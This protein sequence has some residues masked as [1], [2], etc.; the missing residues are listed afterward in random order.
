MKNLITLL[1]VVLIASCATTPSTQ[2]I[3]LTEATLIDF[4]QQ[5]VIVT[6]SLGDRLVAKGYK[7]EGPAYELSE[8]ELVTAKGSLL[9]IC[10]ATNVF[11]QSRFVQRKQPNGDMCAGLFN[12]SLTQAGGATDWN[13]SGNSISSDICYSDSN[14]NFYFG[15]SIYRDASNRAINSNLIKKIKKTTT[16]KINFIQEFIYNGKVNNEVRFI[17]REF[18]E[19]MIRPAFNQSVQYDYDDSKFISFKGLNIEIIEANNQIIK[20]KLL[21]N[22]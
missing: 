7:E 20:Y 4:P 18:S 8:G 2:S 11:P 16:T 19:D 22:F 5:G 6:A 15:S 21:S 17:Y 9:G 10:A 13:C 1:S 14:N 12:I 3:N